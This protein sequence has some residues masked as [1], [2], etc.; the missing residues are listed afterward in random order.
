MAGFRET[1]TAKQ[2]FSVRNMKHLAQNGGPTNVIDN[3]MSALEVVN[4]EAML[5]DVGG[6]IH[7][8]AADILSGIRQLRSTVQ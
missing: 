8:P 5:D 2:F 3:L 4:R 7:G 6:G 1:A